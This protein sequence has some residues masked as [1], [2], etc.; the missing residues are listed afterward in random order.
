MPAAWAVP[1]FAGHPCSAQHSMPYEPVVA[2]VVLQG[3]VWRVLL[4]GLARRQAL[5]RHGC[6]CRE[7]A[8][9]R[10]AS[11]PAAAPR[12][13]P[14]SLS[15]LACAATT[16][17]LQACIRP[18]PSPLAPMLRLPPPQARRLC[19]G[20]SP[21]PWLG[22]GGGGAWPAS[23]TTT[24]SG[25][26][27]R[28]SRSA[29]QAGERAANSGAGPGTERSWLQAECFYFGA[30]GTCGQGGMSSGC[31]ALYCLR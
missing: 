8:R 14:S 23:P 12:W 22:S 9:T 13:R 3:G 10:L 5:L 17:S 20:C 4:R 7:A 31:R 18:L 30:L 25:A 28:R 21:P 6:G 27:P 26:A 15:R 19:S 24:S 2:V 16:P 1:C 11:Q 29:A